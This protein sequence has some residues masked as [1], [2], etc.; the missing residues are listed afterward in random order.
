M[1]GSKPQAPQYI[2]P[3]PPQITQA[4][5]PNIAENSQQIAEARL[6]YDPLLAQS[7][8]DIQ[9]QY[10]PMYRALY[11]QIA[12]TQVR[13][14][15][16]LA[17]QANQRLQSPQGLTPEQQFAQDA[18]RQRS[19][20]ELTRGIR[21]SANVGGTLY[22][23]R[24]QAREDRGLQELEQAFTSQDIQLQDARRAQALQ[25]LIASSQVVFPQVQQPQGVVPT[26]DALLNAFMQG[27]IVQPAQYQPGNPGSPGYFQSWLRGFGGQPGGFY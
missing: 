1:G 4:P 5:A 25:E 17:Q 23:G 26:G 9:A 19:R 24:R 21:E 6:K 11:E 13:G 10:G 16:M 22:G 2:Q 20:D 7:E 15:E 12:P 3:P 14:Q 27:Q 8:Y 18:I